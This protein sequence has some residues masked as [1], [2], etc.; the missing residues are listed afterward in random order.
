MIRVHLVVELMADAYGPH[1][2]YTERF[3]L[4]AAFAK[5]AREAHAKL[6][7]LLV[8]QEYLELPQADAF[9]AIPINSHTVR[10]LMVWE[11]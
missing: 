5:D 1:E 3:H 2:V 7:M 4:P 8:T 6:L 11:G 9:G 10:T